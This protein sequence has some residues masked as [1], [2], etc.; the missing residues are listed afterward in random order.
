[1]ILFADRI[2]RDE[3]LERL[4]WCVFIEFSFVLF[5]A[6]S[7]LYEE[8]IFLLL[9]SSILR[10]L[11]LSVKLKIKR[12]VLLMGSNKVVYVISSMIKTIRLLLTQSTLQVDLVFV[13]LFLNNYFSLP[14]FVLLL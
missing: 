5:G 8:F 14:V 12:R 13:V 9:F 11:F 10:S 1:M 2:I 4:V 6:F 7:V 3:V